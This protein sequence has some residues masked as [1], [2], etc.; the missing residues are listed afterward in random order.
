MQTIDPSLNSIFSVYFF[1]GGC[2]LILMWM[3]SVL[4]LKYKWLSF[5]EKTVDENNYSFSSG[6][7]LQDLGFRGTHL[8]FSLIGK[9]D[10][11]ID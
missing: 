7:F 3:G 8:S 10:V 6:F 9:Q 2:F 11:A 1:I 5:V 4:Y